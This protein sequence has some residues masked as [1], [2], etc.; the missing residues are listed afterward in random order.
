MNYEEEKAKDL[1]DAKHHIGEMYVPLQEC[2]DCRPDVDISVDPATIL[3]IKDAAYAIDVYR[4]E[5]LIYILTY[6]TNDLY[7]YESDVTGRDHV[8]Q[9]ALLE[10]TDFSTAS[11]YCD[12]VFKEVKKEKN[13]RNLMILRL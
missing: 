7:I 2:A 6:G 1:Q 8:G 12:K 10:S 11:E 5:R 9:F 3:E 4:E 13:K